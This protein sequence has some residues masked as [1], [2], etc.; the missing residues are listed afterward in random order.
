MD[1]INL[2]VLEPKE[3]VGLII[4]IT[5]HGKGKTTSALGIA[6]RA[7]GYN[8]RVCI[9]EFMKGDIYSGE[10]DGIKRLSPN[11]EL[12]LTGKGFCGIKGNPYPYKEHRANAQDALKL[13]KEKMLSKK[14]DILILDEINNALQLKLV[15]L[16]QVLELIENKPQLMHLIL[17]GRDA[18]PE[19]IKRAHTV[20]E[21]K[22]IKHAYRQGIEPQ[23]GIDY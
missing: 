6:L 13:A 21:M 17:T 16:P 4:V 11:V 7:I 15:D 10:I 23:K 12:H 20:T 5:G 1:E 14:F 8:M 9:I 18:H 22:E 19:V 2:K 3:K